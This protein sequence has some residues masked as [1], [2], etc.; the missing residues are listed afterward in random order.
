MLLK[1]ELDVSG[2]NFS[3]ILLNQNPLFID[4][5]ED[6]YQLSPGSPAIDAGDIQWLD[7]ETQEDIKGFNRSGSPDLGAYEVE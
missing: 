7:P 3:G 4:F 6:D 5:A 2:P 1:T